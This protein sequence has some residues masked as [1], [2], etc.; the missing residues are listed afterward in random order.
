MKS[1]RLI[2]LRT[3]AKPRKT[4]SPA[5]SSL[6]EAVPGIACSCPSLESMIANSRFESS[7]TDGKK[8]RIGERAS[9]RRA[10]RVVLAD[11]VGA[12]RVAGLEGRSDE[13]EPDRIHDRSGQQQPRQP[14]PIHVSPISS[15]QRRPDEP[16]HSRHG[17]D[18]ACDPQLRAGWIEVL[19]RLPHRPRKPE[20]LAGMPEPDPAHQ[21]NAEAQKHYEYCW[22]HWIL[23]AYADAIMGSE[24]CFR[25][26]AGQRPPS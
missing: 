26:P 14:D 25:S 13:V 6:R 9:P 11:E 16:K 19:R 4:F 12:L 2:A 8:A 17:Y 5:V 7:R 15:G 22:M 21:R 1:T 3:A 20:P 24:A 18:R 10:R 23:P